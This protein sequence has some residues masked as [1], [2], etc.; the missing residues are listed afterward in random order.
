VR[1]LASWTLIA[2][3]G[4]GGA[5]VALNSFRFRRAVSAEA[6]HMWGVMAAPHA[7]DRSRLGALPTPARA[8]L[9]RALCNRSTTVA[10]V[11]FRHGGR[12]RTTLD[13]AWQPIRGEQH[14]TADPPAFIWWGRLPIAPGLWVDAR[15]RC[16]GGSGSMLISFE[17]MLTLG[18][19]SGPE[20]DQGSMLRLLS[21]FVVFPTAFLDGRYVSWSEVDQARARV[22]LRLHGRSVTGTLEFGEDGLPRLFSAKRYFDSGKGQAVLRPWSGD[23]GDYREVAGMLVP[24]HFVGYWHLDGKRIPYADFEIERAEYDSPAPY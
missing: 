20:L 14:D 16:V 21:D 7:L 2:A 24:H 10:T 23:Y 11:R 19:R 3:I 8:Y 17:S 15:D 6:R 12:F 13:G 18:D 22:S 1:R 4:V 5:A 9:E